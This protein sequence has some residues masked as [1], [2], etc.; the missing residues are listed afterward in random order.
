MQLMYN[1]VTGHTT[2]DDEWKPRVCP[3]TMPDGTARDLNT[4][5]PFLVGEEHTIEDHF[6]RH[7][8]ELRTLIA[9]CMADQREDRPSLAQLLEEI[10]E[11]ILRGDVRAYEAQVAFNDARLVN[12]TLQKPPVDVS[13][14]PHV[15]DDDLLRRFFFEYLREPPVVPDIFQD[16]WE[17]GQE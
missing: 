4:W 8:I 3:I 12:P 5:A 14:P 11:N 13:R 17:E 1:A 15:E 10:Q 2:I 7:S 6:K 9:R 16:L